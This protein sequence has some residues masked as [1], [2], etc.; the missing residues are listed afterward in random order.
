MGCIFGV[1]FKINLLRAQ[2]YSAVMG[3]LHSHAPL[4]TDTP[5]DAPAAKS[6]C[7]VTNVLK[8]FGMG[9]VWGTSVSQRD[10]RLALSIPERLRRAVH[11]PPAGRLIADLAVTTG[12]V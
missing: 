4:P 12:C 10:N 8:V 7:Q 3:V 5:P 6:G 9:A 11:N 1:L 2:G